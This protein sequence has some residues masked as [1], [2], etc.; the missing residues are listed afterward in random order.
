MTR[1]G[2]LNEAVAFDPKKGIPLELFL[3]VSCTLGFVFSD[4]SKKHRFSTISGPCPRGTLGTL[5]PGAGAGAGSGAGW[6]SLSH[7]SHHM[8]RLPCALAIHPVEDKALFAPCHRGLQASCSLPHFG[9][10]LLVRDLQNASSRVHDLVTDGLTSAS[11]RSVPGSFGWRCRLLPGVES[12]SCATTVT[13][14]LPRQNQACRWPS[15]F[16]ILPRRRTVPACRMLCH[17]SSRL[18]GET[19]LSKSQMPARTSHDRSYRAHGWR[20]SRHAKGGAVVCHVAKDLPLNVSRPLVAR[21]DPPFRHTFTISACDTPTIKVPAVFT[22]A[23]SKSRSNSSK[24]TVR[25][26]E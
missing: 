26:S 2:C 17:A 12:H 3:L 10:G 4:G 8:M 15:L 5:G 11:T 16:G 18:T 7:E 13:V 25:G 1:L 23:C 9:R 20:P 14:Q 21:L 22:C 6:L 19:K 24:S